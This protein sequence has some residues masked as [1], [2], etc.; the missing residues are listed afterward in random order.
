[1]KF[2]PLWIALFFTGLFARAGNPDSLSHFR[3]HIMPSRLVPTYTADARAHRTQLLKTTQ[4]S[5]FYGSMGGVFPIVQAS[6]LHTPVQFSAAASTY[7]TLKR[8]VQRGEVINTD[9]FV[10]FLFDAQVTEDWYVRLGFGH[11]SQHLA[12]DAL[13]VG[14]V[15]RN[16]VKDYT[17]IQVMRYVWHKRMLCYGGAYYFKNFKIG[18]SIPVNWSGK[19]M[20]QAGTEVDVYRI[21]SSSAVYA[22]VDVK[23]RQEFDF[24]TTRGIQLGLKY[25]VPQTRR[26][27]RLAYHYLSGY[28]ERGQFYKDQINLHTLGVYFDF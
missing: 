26:A 23:F 17:Q 22:A 5:A 24:R 15:P 19:I 21:T 1:M 2:S 10:D 25:H 12:D 28:E 13:G 4:G 27:M 8:Y 3:L 20:L 18:D 9:Y 6:V 16:Y 14:F 11:T 7:L